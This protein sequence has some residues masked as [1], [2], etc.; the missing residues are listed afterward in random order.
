MAH[1]VLH[2]LS[3]GRRDRADTRESPRRYHGRRSRRGVPGDETLDARLRSPR[4][5]GAPTPSLP[6]SLV[7]A[8]RFCGSMATYRIPNEARIRE[9]LVRVFSTR[10]MVESQRRL[11]ALVE[12]DLKGEE[13]YR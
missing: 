5:S 10:P 2:D 1:D 8:R 3:L 4:M 6:E 7:G 12:K 13:K 9:S 11:K